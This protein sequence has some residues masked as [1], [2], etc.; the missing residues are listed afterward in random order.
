MNLHILSQIFDEIKTSH[1]LELPLHE[2]ES[3]FAELREEVL[4]GNPAHLTLSISLWGMQFKYPE[5]ELAKDVAEAIEIAENAEKQLMDYEKN[6]HFQHRLNRTEIKTLV[7][8]KLFGSRAALIACFNLI[9]AY[10]NGLAWDFLQSNTTIS[11]RRR[12]FLDDS[13]SVSIREKLLKYPEIIT[14]TSPWKEDDSSLPNCIS[15]IISNQ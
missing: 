15:E 3:R 13:A 2:F 14:G 9:E 7:R 11:N 6:T 12:K 5:D 1:G 8:Q 4:L 10:L